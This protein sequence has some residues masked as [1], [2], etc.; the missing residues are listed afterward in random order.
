MNNMTLPEPS[1]KEY[2]SKKKGKNEVREV[3][4]RKADGGYIVD[5][6]MKNYEESRKPKVY[7]DLEGVMEC[8]KENLK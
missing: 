7:A 3:I 4:I 2:A 1:M 6:N 5:V 8:L